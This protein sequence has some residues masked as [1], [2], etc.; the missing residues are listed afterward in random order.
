MKFATSSDLMNI[1][2]LSTYTDLRIDIEL[3]RASNR[4]LGLLNSQWWPSYTRA[5]PQVQGPLDPQLLDEYTLRAMTIYYALAYLVL[6]KINNTQDLQARYHN[7]WERAWRESMEFG[8]TYDALGTTHAQPAE[9]S[10]TDYLRLR[11]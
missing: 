2:D 9:D 7:L 1:E 5:N 8:I 3:E 6:P 4:I 11:T 10:P